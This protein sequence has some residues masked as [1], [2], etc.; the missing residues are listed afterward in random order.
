[1]PQKAG[2][3]AAYTPHGAIALA[4]FLFHDTSP[5]DIPT[6][7]PT[8]FDGKI[9]LLYRDYNTTARN[10]PPVYDPT[11]GYRGWFCTVDLAPVS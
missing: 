8:R 4:P 2:Y 3:I 6:L 9:G 5:I 10:L 7:A 1:M 11:A